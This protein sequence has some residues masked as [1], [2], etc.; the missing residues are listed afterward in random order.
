MHGYPSMYIHG[1][2]SMGM[3][4]RISFDIP[5]W[6][7]IYGDPTMNIHAYPSMDIQEWIPCNDIH[8]YPSMDIHP[9]TSILGYSWICIHGYPWIF[10][11]G[12]V[13]E[14]L[15]NS[16]RRVGDRPSWILISRTPARKSKIVKHIAA[17]Q[18]LRT[19]RINH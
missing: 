19:V 1:S 16:W 4:Q 14:G 2:P 15:L 3:N 18:D 7:S 8:G 5:T 17:Q 10:I 13:A 12:Q 6:I 9:W 11:F